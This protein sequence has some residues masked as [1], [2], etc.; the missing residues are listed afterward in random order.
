MRHA[1]ILCFLLLAVTAGI[2]LPTGGHPFISFDDPGYV[3]DNPRVKG[4]LTGEN[5][6]W[7]FSSTAMSNW[8][9]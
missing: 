2:Y 3:T 8:H 6:V 1:L 4:G 5:V 9:P 7:A